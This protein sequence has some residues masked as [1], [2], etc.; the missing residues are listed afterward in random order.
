MS[1]LTMEAV[2]LRDSVGL[3]A[4]DVAAATG[5]APSTARAWLN[6]TRTPSG[7]RLERL[8]ELL[9]VVERTRGVI[10]EDYVSPWM[11][12]PVR[13]LDDQKPIE[14]IRAGEYL[15]VLGVIAGLEATNAS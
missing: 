15:R 14:L 8:M 6:G 4:E 11:R 5:A 1:T 9:S 3:S 2:A 12:K 7:E 13:L 10:P